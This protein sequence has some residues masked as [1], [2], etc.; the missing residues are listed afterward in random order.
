MTGSEGNTEY[1]YA[2]IREAIVEGRYPPSCR[3]VEQKVA[4]E[5]NLSRTPVREALKMLAAEGLVTIERNVGAMVRPID[6]KTIV[7]LYELRARL[8][9]YA[10]SRAAVHRTPE[11]LSAL[12]AAV[13][14]FSAAV[15]STVVHDVES[16]RLVNVA[17]AAIHS[18]VTAAA[19]HERLAS[20]LHRAVDVPLVFQAFRRFDREQLDRSDLFHRL[21]HE[22]IAAQDPNRAERLML[23]HIDQGRDVLLDAVERASIEMV[24]ETPA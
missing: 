1:A 3:L 8:E 17:N 20:M 23:E 22:A 24:F 16:M 15:G 7:D 19:A 18:T 2:R 9:S 21:I 10:A 13:A 11:Q 4:A 14:D 6:R 5:L 12:A